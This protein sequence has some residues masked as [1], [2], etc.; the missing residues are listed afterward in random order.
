MALQPKAAFLTQETRMFLEMLLLLVQVG[1]DDYGAVQFH[2]HTPALRR[3][4]VLVP[5]AEWFGDILR[6]R[7]D[8]VNRAC[9]LSRLQAFV[10]FYVPVIV[11]DLNFHAVVG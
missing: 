9:V 6:R 8:A 4:S 1:I 2:T 7:H 5:L 11:E 10:I 3:Y